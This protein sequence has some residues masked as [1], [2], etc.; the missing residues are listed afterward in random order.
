[1]SK[2]KQ[3]QSFNAFIT[4]KDYMHCLME[5]PAGFYYGVYDGKVCEV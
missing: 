4:I 5:A 3:K 1:M 2:L